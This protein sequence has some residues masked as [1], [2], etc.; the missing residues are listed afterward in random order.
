MRRRKFIAGIGV[1]L[2][3]SLVA[4]AQQK[5]VT[6][7]FLGASSKAGVVSW[8]DALVNQLRELGWVEGRNLVFEYRFAEGL[9]ERAAVI[10]AEFASLKVDVIITHSNAAV[11]AAKKATTSIPIVF[12]AV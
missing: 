3:T 11:I 4:R 1:A 7:G 12:G 5:P 9:P 2:T 10:A 8:I 6:I